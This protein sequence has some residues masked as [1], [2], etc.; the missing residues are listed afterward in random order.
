MTF[1][2]NYIRGSFFQYNSDLDKHSAS[3]W[4]TSN[5]AYFSMV[6]VKM[7]MPSRKQNKK[8]IKLQ[9]LLSVTITRQSFGSA[10]LKEIVK[11]HG[12]S[13]QLF[14]SFKRITK[15]TA[16][17]KVESST[18]FQPLMLLSL[19]SIFLLLLS[20]GICIPIEMCIQYW[21]CG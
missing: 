19:G 17:P 2:M 14:N 12:K 8:L 20:R 13:F 5:A 7:L 1:N 3:H 4:M 21:N 10:S 18:S 16:A 11:I 15:Q 6:N 9:T